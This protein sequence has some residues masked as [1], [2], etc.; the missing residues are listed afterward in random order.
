[1]TE[2]KTPKARLEVEILSAQ[3]VWEVHAASGVSR[4]KGMGQQPHQPARPTGWGASL[5]AAA[6]T[7]MLHGLLI[8]G[9]V[10]GTAGRPM[11][12]REPQIEGMALQVGTIAAESAVLVFINSSSI[13]PA[14]W[15]PEE[16][17]FSSLTEVPSEITAA[18]V[19]SLASMSPPEIGSLSGT[20]ESSPTEEATGDESAGRALLFGRY[21]GQIKARIERAWSYPPIT[22]TARFECRVQIKQD[23]RGQ[24]Q[25][26]T[27]QRCGEDPAWQLSLVQA[28]Q[29]A[30]PLSG[31]PDDS[32]FT[33]I[34]TM[35]FASQQMAAQQNDHVPINPS[36]SDHLN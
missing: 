14:D 30:S 33:E 19:A 5:A 20:D 8:G 35:L 17:S 15:T 3:G 23:Q 18:L 4:P 25:E 2:R 24:V 16:L 12:K 29:Q 27:L 26:V 32:V 6:G 21:M 13:T 9:I 22:S 1:M 31:P 34:V 11:M 7:L 28:I 36:P 10:L